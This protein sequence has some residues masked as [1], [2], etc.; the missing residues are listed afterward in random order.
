MDVFCNGKVTLANILPSANI[1]PDF[2]GNIERNRERKEAEPNTLT[3]HSNCM[4]L[5]HKLH[6]NERKENRL[7]FTLSRWQL[8]IFMYCNVIV[9]W[10]VKNE[11]HSPQFAYLLA[12]LAFDHRSLQT[13]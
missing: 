8:H 1:L 4:T 12:M 3:Q 2:H 7:H 11:F 10:G 9:F 13:V 6:T 5:L